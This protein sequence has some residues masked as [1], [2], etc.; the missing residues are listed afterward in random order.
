MCKELSAVFRFD[1]LLLWPLHGNVGEEIGDGLSIM[2]T[3]DG[4]GQNHGDV[5]ALKQD[6]KNLKKA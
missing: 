5:D 6:N 2:C 4:F 1:W 3:A